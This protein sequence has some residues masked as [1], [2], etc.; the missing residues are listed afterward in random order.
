MGS[1]GG[2]FTFGD[3]PFDGTSSGTAGSYVSIVGD[4][5][6]TLQAIFDQ[7]AARWAAHGLH[8]VR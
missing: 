3:A 6:P 1:D 8:H 2:I 7:P 5:P 4:A